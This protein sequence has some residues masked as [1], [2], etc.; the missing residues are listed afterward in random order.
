MIKVKTWH[1]NCSLDYTKRGN[2]RLEG[3]RKN[4]KDSNYFSLIDFGLRVIQLSLCNASPQHLLDQC[5]HAYTWL[6]DGGLLRFPRL[7]NGSRK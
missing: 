7:P 1:R 3:G 5:R 4:E 2:C 6:L